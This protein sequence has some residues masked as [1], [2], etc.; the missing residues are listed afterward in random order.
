M[1]FAALKRG[2]KVIATARPKSVS[3]LTELKA[4]GAATLALDV[5]DSLDNLKAIAEE[6]VKIYGRVDVL[7][8]NAAYIEVGALEEYT[9]E[10]TFAQYK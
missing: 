7:V 1:A 6:A 4:A 9:P 8:N 2:D 5:T 10:E 3:R